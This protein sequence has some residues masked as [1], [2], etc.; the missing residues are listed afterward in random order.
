MKKKLFFFRLQIQKVFAA[1]S[2][3]EVQVGFIESCMV[4]G[5]DEISRTIFKVPSPLKKPSSSPHRKGV[6][7]P[8]LPSGGTGSSLW[9]QKDWKLQNRAGD[10]SP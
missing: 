5:E 8:P 1:G 9:Q 4:T 10:G 3:S 2:D 6:D 7:P